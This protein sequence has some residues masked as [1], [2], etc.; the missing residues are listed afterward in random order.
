MYLQLF[1][2]VKNII[3]KISE[4]ELIA[5]RSGGVSIDRD[6][7]SGKLYYDK[8][9]KINISNKEHENNM[10]HLTK[11]ILRKYGDTKVYPSNNI[12][13]I[14][15][16][17]G[18]KGFLGMIIDKKYGGN[19]LQ[20][21]TQS[22]ILTMM[23]SYNPSLA[24]VTMVPNS[25]GPGE[26]L[27]HYG[28]EFQKNNY[29][30]KLATGKLI[31]CFG[32]TGPNNGSDATGNID[33][34]I[35]KENNGNKY[36]EIE[37]NKRYITLAPIADL[38]G[39]AFNLKD[40][41]NLLK[42]GK[43]GITLA[44]IERNHLGLLQETYHN[45]NNAGFPNGTLKGKIQINLDQII[46]GEKMAGNGWLM[47][48]ECLAVG[49]GVS[50]PAS[51]NGTSKAITF[52]ILNYI[53]NREQFK[54]PI[55]MMQGIREKF[56]EMFYNTWVIQSSVNFTAHILDSGSVPSV[57]TAIMKQQTTERARKVLLNGMDIYAGSAICEGPNNYF[58]K[59]YNSSPIGITVEGSNILTRSLII[60]GQGLNKS[61]PYIYN[62]FDSI[63]TNNLNK[64]KNE[65]NNMIVFST[66]LYL[67]SVLANNNRNANKRLEILIKKFANLANFVALLGGKIKSEQMISGHMADILSNI[68]LAQSVIWY[69]NNSN[70]EL[71]IE[72]R[73]YCI[74]KLCN[75]A[76]QKVNLI[77]NNYP[78]DIVKLLLKPTQYKVNYD[79]FKNENKIYD[80][81]IKNDNIHKLLKENIFYEN[82]VIQN[83]EKLT[84]MK[85][86]SDKVKYNE[87]YKNVIS[88]GE[89]KINTVNDQN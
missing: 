45:P 1:S 20:I 79:E 19:R 30:P 43:A 82:T 52:G 72:I 84:E 60:F 2:R 78:T 71:P 5:L 76:E 3:P 7:F 16:E 36:I 56:L 29:L 27:Q 83:L 21:S 87:L 13:N 46:G 9:N 26:L 86:N 35:L 32:L 25:L 81:I 54:M 89:F 48:M 18:Q 65:F 50:L 42:D 74:N 39:V 4:T 88:V 49:R 17:L 69:H 59:F 22:K 23:A 6:I 51:A 38:I 61:H 14:M 40:P 75:E 12:K 34:G 68:Y 11:N 24:V 28:T 64:F 44:L 57:L 85:N 73:D 62:I 58:T 77:I 70:E 80:K 55:G 53:Q 8:L 41:D 15:N 37:L 67:S 10:L 33:I 47:L 66:K 31:P 63:Q